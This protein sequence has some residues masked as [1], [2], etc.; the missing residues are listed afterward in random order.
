MAY[1]AREKMRA[2]QREVN[3]R[4][5]VYAKRIADGKMTQAKAD[6]EIAI[7][8][9]IARDYGAQAIAEEQ[10]ERLV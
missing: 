6:A 2:A 1:T 8:D 10:K 5:Y 4:R 3:Y 9:E 7:M